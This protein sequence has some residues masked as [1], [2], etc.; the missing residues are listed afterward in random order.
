M[1]AHGLCAGDQVV[2]APRR[3]PE[4]G[5]LVALTRSSGMSPGGPQATLCKTTLWKAYPES[6]VLHLRCGDATLSLAPDAPIVGVVVAVRRAL[7][8]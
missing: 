4:F 5:D 6:G 3:E 8:P 2:L 7:L 1:A